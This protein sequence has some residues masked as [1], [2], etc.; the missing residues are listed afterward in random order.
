MLREQLQ[1]KM[2]KSDFVMQVYIMFSVIS[3]NVSSFKFDCHEILRLIWQPQFPRMN[4][5]KIAFVLRNKMSCI[6]SDQSEAER[7]TEL[8]ILNLHFFFTFAAATSNAVIQAFS[9][10][11]TIFVSHSHSK[12][13]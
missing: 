1:W 8:S 4:W 11:Q 6:Q 9:W 7:Q 12:P 2:P 3:G 13:A 5:M 10:K